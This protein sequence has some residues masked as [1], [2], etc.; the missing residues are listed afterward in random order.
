MHLKPAHL[1]IATGFLGEP[2]IPSIPGSDNFA[3]DILHSNQYGGGVAFKGK[4]VVVV[5]AGNSSADICQ[6][7]VFRGAASVTMVQRSSTCVVSQKTVNQRLA[8]SFP[9]NLPVEVSDFKFAAMP[10]LLRRAFL[11]ESQ[12]RVEEED[13][14]MLEGLRNAGFR[15]NHGGMDDSGTLLLFYER[16]GG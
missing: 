2:N 8:I 6:D 10:F 11:K 14:E 12:K 7:L 15:L 3:G 5:G 16:G 1:I 4:R 13:K 9:E